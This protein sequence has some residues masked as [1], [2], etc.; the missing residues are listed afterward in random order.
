[1]Y[2]WLLQLF[3]TVICSGRWPYVALVSLCGCRPTFYEM[4]ITMLHEENMRLSIDTIGIL[5]RCLTA[6]MIPLVV[7]SSMSPAKAR[8]AQYE[9]HL[10]RWSEQIKLTASPASLYL[11]S[12]S[13]VSL[14]VRRASIYTLLPSSRT[15]RFGCWRFCANS[16]RSVRVSEVANGLGCALQATRDHWLSEDW[17]F[18]QYARYKR[19]HHNHFIS[20]Q[21]RTVPKNDASA[22]LFVHDTMC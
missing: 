14:F 17:D 3:S 4:S 16:A 22:T 11:W 13:S 19:R 8:L 12:L 18:L 15:M 5:T 10:V 21:W 7:T 20:N 9:L 6:G 2:L 1:M